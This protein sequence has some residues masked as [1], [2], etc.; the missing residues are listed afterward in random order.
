MLQCR[1]QKTTKTQPVTHVLTTLHTPDGTPNVTHP[2]ESL[3]HWTYEKTYDGV[4]SDMTYATVV[5]EQRKQ[6]KS[7]PHGTREMTTLTFQTHNTT[8]PRSELVNNS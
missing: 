8:S 6:T 2:Y 7:Q 3:H 1:G 5:R 4:V